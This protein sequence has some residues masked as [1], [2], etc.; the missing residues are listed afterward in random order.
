LL[1][2]GGEG[3]VRRTVIRADGSTVEVEVTR[4]VYLGYVG[5]TDDGEMVVAYADD[6]EALPSE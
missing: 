4:E 6:K 2:R 1:R 5:Y 3:T